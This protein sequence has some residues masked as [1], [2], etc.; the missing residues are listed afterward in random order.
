MTNLQFGKRSGR[1]A[2]LLPVCGWSRGGFEMWMNSWRL[3]AS[4]A[5]PTSIT[6]CQLSGELGLSAGTHSCG[7]CT[8][9]LSF[10]LAW[11]LGLESEHPEDK[12]KVLGNFYD[13]VSLWHCSTDQSGHKGGSVSRKGRTCPITQWE[14]RYRITRTSCGVGHVVAE[15]CLK[16]YH[17][18][19]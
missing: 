8:W 7:F 11:W 18:S 1:T 15:S 4:H 10:P 6:G 12:V 2:S 19:K 3:E 17:L 9:L 5:Y 13:P 16:K 14:C